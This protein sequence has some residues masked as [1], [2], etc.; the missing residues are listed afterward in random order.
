MTEQN[1]TKETAASNSDAPRRS[2][3]PPAIRDFLQPLVV[4]GTNAGTTLDCATPKP[5]KHP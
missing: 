2:Y 4:L 1:K 3:E 5:P